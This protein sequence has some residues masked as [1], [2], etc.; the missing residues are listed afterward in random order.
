MHSH[1]PLQCPHASHCTCLHHL[2]TT[3]STGHVAAPARPETRGTGPDRDDSAVRPRLD[4]A[5]IER[6]PAVSRGDPAPLAAGVAAAGRGRHHGATQ[7]AAAG[8]GPAPHGHSRP[9]AV[10]AGTARRVFPGIGFRAGHA[11]SDPA[12]CPV[13]PPVLT[14][15]GRHLSAH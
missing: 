14:G 7:G 5:A 15:N 4:C 10:V 11:L 1:Y 12:Q 8:C 13:D 3:S 9:A 6:A 2:S